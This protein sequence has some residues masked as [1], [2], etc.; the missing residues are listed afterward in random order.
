MPSSSRHL[1]TAALDKL[2]HYKADARS[3]ESAIALLRAQLSDALERAS[4]A[5]QQL[6]VSHLR[7]EHAQQA[8]CVLESPL[9]AILTH[10]EQRPML[11]FDRQSSTHPLLGKKQIV[12]ALSFIISANRS[13]SVTHENKLDNKAMIKAYSK[14]TKAAIKA[15]RKPMIKASIHLQTSTHHHNFSKPL[16][17]RLSRSLVK[18]MNSVSNAS[19]SISSTLSVNDYSVSLSN[20]NTISNAL[21]KTSLINFKKSY[22][23]PRNTQTTFGVA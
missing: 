14:L 17:I 12:Y 4:T 11:T 10:T 23:I 22:K 2:D 16:L 9:V 6:A 3:L 20:I 19:L 18:T 5:H 7:L 13:M 15:Y 1:L 8:L 21:P